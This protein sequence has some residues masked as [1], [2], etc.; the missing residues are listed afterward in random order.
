MNVYAPK[1][2]P[3]DTIGVV[4]PSD[5][6]ID[7]SALESGINKLKELGF[8]VKLAPN[9]LSNTLGY[10]ATPQEKADDINQMFAD[11]SVQAIICAQGGENANSVL[12]LLDYDL[13]TKNP[14]IFLGI[15]DITVLL[16][17]IYAKTGLITFHGNDVMW[18]FGRNPDQY[19]LDEL[20]RKLMDA[21]IGMVKKNSEWKTIRE[22]VAEGKLLGGNAACIGKLLGTEYIPDFTDVIL[23]LESFGE[24]DTPTKTS[25]TLH[26]LDQAGIFKK[27][28]GLLLGYYKTEQQTEIE[29]I[30]REVTNKYN[31]PILKCDDFGHNTPNTILPIGVKVKLDSNSCSL[32]FLESYTK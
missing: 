31:F 7:K 23:F 17:G 24:L 32:S 4:S 12:P 11:S 25:Y 26:Q 3:G 16:N 2:K 9:A 27:I 28:K 22:G 18:G 14:K 13:I 5:P 20:K 8:K 15:S 1:L 21:E 29:D 19:E 30:A 6:V 10:S